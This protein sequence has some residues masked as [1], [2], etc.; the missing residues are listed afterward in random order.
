M[1]SAPAAPTATGPAPE[2]GATLVPATAGAAV[3]A[4]TPEFRDHLVASGIRVVR[5]VHTDLFGR[6]RAKQLPLS[7]WCS[8]AAGL[9]YSK[10]ASAEDLLG[11]PVREE[12][13]PHLA[14]HPDLH[15]VPDAA[16]LFFPPWEP[17]SVWV[18][19]TLTERGRPSALC[20]RAQLVAASDRLAQDHGLRAVAAG[21]PE[22]YLFEQAGPHAAPT[23][24][25]Q[26]GVSYTVDR[27]TDPR[28]VVGRIHRQL[29]DL[30]IGVTVVNREFSPGQFEI[31]LHHDGALAAADA[32]FLLKS[33]VKEIAAIEGLEANFMAKPRTGHEGNGLHVHVSLWDGD[34]NVFGTADGGLS[35]QALSAIAGLQAHAP[36]LMALAAPT[37]NSYKRL[38]GEGLSPRS[39]NWGRD[40]RLTFVRVPPE[41]G[42][43]TRLEL[44]CGDASASSHL[45]LAAMLHAMR[46]GLDRALTP[47]DAGGPLP[48]DLEDALQAL[49][50]D[51]VL[52]AGFGAEFVSIYAALKRA[53]I[54]A[55]R[56]AVTDW[57]WQVYRLHV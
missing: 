41:R 37:V 11:V 3:P 4:F 27:V 31:N 5:V 21:E 9:A 8:L 29:I 23:A 48:L 39:S 33:S 42:D 52:H 32:A 53:E 57:E 14:G 47:T 25:S 43:A 22:F 45:L 40:N 35:P 28:G 1:T 50:T 55:F 15:A 6:Q 12:Q 24:Y 26:A 16:R 54:S 34:V 2:T 56:Q 51:D 10:V 13:F 36:A 17:D 49:E 44:R 20:P 18:L 46:D 7:A 30:G 19:A 38:S